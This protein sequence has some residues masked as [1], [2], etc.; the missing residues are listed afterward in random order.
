MWWS[1]QVADR[2]GA[3]VL[4]VGDDERPQAVLR[5][6]Q[7]VRRVCQLRRQADLLKVRAVARHVERERVGAR[8]GLR[9]R[10][11]LAMDV[12]GADVGVDVEDLRPRVR[13][14]EG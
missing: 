4:V 5:A 3:L 9:L 7:R 1:A 2:G 8:D 14:W 6:D 13:A 10:V 12:D 11:L